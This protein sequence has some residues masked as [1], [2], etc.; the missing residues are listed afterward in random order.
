LIGYGEDTWCGD[1]YRPG[2]TARGITNFALACYRR[3]ITP[4]G[5]LRGGEDEENYGLD[6]AEYV[7]AVGVETAVAALP[8]LIR[9]ELL[10]D[11]RAADVEV[12]IV[13]EEVQPGGW[14]LTIKEIIS[15]HD[16]A[17]A[18]ELTL[19]VTEDGATLIGT[20]VL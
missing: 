10:K 20:R 11:D 16:D 3:Q 1:R 13:S 19:S 18:F 15:G 17:E 7:G 9:G 6:V 5:V 4:R 12:S 2:R 14:R 8:G